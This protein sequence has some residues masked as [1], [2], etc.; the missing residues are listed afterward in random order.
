MLNV[1]ILSVVAPRKQQGTNV[2]KL[3]F[4]FKNC[5]NK[6]QRLSLAGLSSLVYCEQD[7]RLPS[8]LTRK[9]FTKMERLARDKH[10]S[11]FGTFVVNKA[12]KSFITL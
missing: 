11:L 1:I 12:E 6:L 5:Q 10:S 2:I 8:G 7:Q 9:H 3:F 4:K